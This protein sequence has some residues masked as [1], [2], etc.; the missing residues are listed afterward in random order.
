[1]NDDIRRMCQEILNQTDE[2]RLSLGR[3]AFENMVRGFHELGL[4]SE[5]TVN[6]IQNLT[7]LFVSAD[8]RCNLPEYDFYRAVTGSNISK[9]DFFDMT[10]YGKDEEF[11]NATCELMRHAD[12]QTR[13]A[14]ILFGL[15]L[16]CHDGTLKADEQ[17]LIDKLMD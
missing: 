12:R 2:E 7:K 6:L 16:M 11:V 17:I 15:A 5:K 9:D 10:N 1:M 13:T 8:G 4:N 3:E 14:T